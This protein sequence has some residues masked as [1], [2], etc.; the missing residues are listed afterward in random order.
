MKIS[1]KKKFV[2]WHWLSEIR[3]EE[4][5]Y[6]FPQNFS[7]IINIFSETSRY[8]LTECFRLRLVLNNWKLNSCYTNIRIFSI[9]Q[10]ELKS[11]PLY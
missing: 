8:D 3:D 11:R 4:K 6:I 1:Q 9:Y 2:S 5:N 10:N 7:A